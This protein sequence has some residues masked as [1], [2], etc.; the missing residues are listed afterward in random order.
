AGRGTNGATAPAEAAS[1]RAGRRHAAARSGPAL[2][3]LGSPW[4]NQLTIV[5]TVSDQ[6]GGVPQ[7][8][9]ARTGKGGTSKPLAGRRPLVS[10]GRDHRVTHG[11]V[12]GVIVGQGLVECDA[13][14][15]RLKRFIARMGMDRRRLEANPCSVDTEWEIGRM[16]EFQRGLQFKARAYAAAPAAAARR[17][18]DALDRD[19]L[20][21]MSTAVNVQPDLVAHRDVG[22]VHRPDGGVTGIRGPS[23]TSLCSRLAHLGDGDDLIT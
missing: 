2:V 3:A 15:Q 8:D 9:A 4:V 23:Q 18:D 14:A 5:E 19:G 17:R 10:G 1:A 20:D 16:I 21:A 22:P 6:A 7:H 11:G 12:D 13:G